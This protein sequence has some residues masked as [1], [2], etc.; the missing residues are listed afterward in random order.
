MIITKMRRIS[1]ILL[2]LGSILSS[3]TKNEIKID[4]DNL[5]I[6]TWNYSEYTG[7]LNIYTRSLDFT[8]THCYKFNSDGSFIE[9]SISGWCATPPVSYSNYPGTWTILNDTLIQI[10]GTYWGGATTFKLDIES[11]TTTSLKVI[12]VSVS[13]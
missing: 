2:L 9:R 4:P 12:R 5:L 7:D 1:L 3:C 6:G 11:V 13:E 10:N 8:D